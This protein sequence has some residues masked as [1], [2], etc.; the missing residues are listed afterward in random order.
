MIK[1]PTHFFENYKGL[2]GT[3]YEVKRISFMMDIIPGKDYTAELRPVWVF[4]TTVSGE[5]YSFESKSS[6][7]CCEWSGIDSLTGLLSWRLGQ[8]AL[9]AFALNLPG[10]EEI[11]RTL[12]LYKT[13][14]L[15]GNFR[16]DMKRAFLK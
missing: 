2:V 15:Y 9:A 11:F 14:E 1:R 10:I 13:G 4:D 8:T 6:Y 16:M 3:S 12:G 7:R 5:D